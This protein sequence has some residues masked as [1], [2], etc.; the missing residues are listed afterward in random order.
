M[1]AQ[2]ARGSRIGI[3]SLTDGSAGHHQLSRP[4]LARRR[5]KEAQ[6]AAALLGAE[7]TVW[8]VPDGEL[9]PELGLRQRLIRTIRAFQRNC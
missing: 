6:S 8:E 7:L 4:E 2:A 9:V 3:L 1:V 5:L